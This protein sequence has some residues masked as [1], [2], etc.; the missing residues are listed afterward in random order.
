MTRPHARTPRLIIA[1]GFSLFLLALAGF[2]PNAVHASPQKYHCDCDP[3]DTDTSS[4][5]CDYSY[6]LKRS[7]TKEFRGYCSYDNGWA[8]HPVFYSH[9][10]KSMT[11]TLPFPV[12]T[13]YD[14]KSCTNW[15]ALHKRSVSLRLNCTNAWEK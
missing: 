5:Y 2:A 14:S 6:E 12:G 1:T 15:S 10:D 7:A 11:C 8:M 9:P 3:G 4:C 13:L